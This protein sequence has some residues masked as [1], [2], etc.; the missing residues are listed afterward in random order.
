[1]HT[2]RSK[3]SR[4]PLPNTYP[5]ALTEQYFLPAKNAIYFPTLILQHSHNFPNLNCMHKRILH[6]N[7]T[8]YINAQETYATCRWIYLQYPQ[9]VNTCSNRHLATFTLNVYA[10][11]VPKSSVCWSPNQRTGSPGKENILHGTH[12]ENGIQLEWLQTLG[13]ARR[14][15]DKSQI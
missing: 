9:T 2:E 15:I 14:P 7:G 11:Y 13:K 4:G 12:P 1:M 6:N 3:D 8:C 10:P 5:A